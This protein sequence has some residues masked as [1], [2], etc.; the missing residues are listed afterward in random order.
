[1]EV[2]QQDGHAAGSTEPAHREH[3]AAVVATSAPSPPA[4][5]GEVDLTWE[6]SKENVRPLTRGRK[7][8]RL[9]RAFGAPV[10]DAS[11]G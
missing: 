8:E 6:L 11:I 3:G 1:M 9:K 4:D 10:A 2:Q 5:G 7:V